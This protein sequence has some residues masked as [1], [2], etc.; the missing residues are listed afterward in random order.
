MEKDR[1]EKIKELW[2]KIHRDNFPSFFHWQYHPEMRYWYNEDT[3][4]IE[5]DCGLVKPVTLTDDELNDR[6]L[7]ELIDEIEYQIYID[8]KKIGWDLGYWGD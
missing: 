6:N 2:K 1:K 4:A 8:Y 5:C 3:D 7:R